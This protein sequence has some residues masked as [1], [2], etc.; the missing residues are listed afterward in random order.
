MLELLILVR[1]NP[2]SCLG[3]WFDIIF[4]L[5]LQVKKTRVKLGRKDLKMGPNSDSTQYIVGMNTSE[6][7]L[8]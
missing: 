7:Y 1:P 3:G 8:H 5:G 6:P 4:G 2:T